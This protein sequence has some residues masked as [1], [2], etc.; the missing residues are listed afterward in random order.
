MKQA[1]APRGRPDELWQWME[2][3]VSPDVMVLTEAKVPDGGPPA[4]WQAVWEPDGIGPKRRWG[5]V[6]AG[7]GVELV[8]VTEMTVGRFRRRTVPLTP[9]IPAAAVVSDVVVEGERWATV[10]GLYGL[11]TDLDG[12][13]VGHGAFTLQALLSDLLPLLSSNRN[14]RLILAGDFNLCPDD[15]RQTIEL[16]DLRNLTDFTRSSRAPLQGCTRCDAP[17]PKECGHFWTHRNG[18]SPN[19][20]VQNIDYIFASPDL[21][22]ELIGMSGGVGDY[23]DAWDVSDHAPVVADFRR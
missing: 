4:G 19:A 23:P 7:R 11:T 1:V 6:V 3:N 10:V 20:A 13:K 14:K 15:L 16:P 18:N 8:P 12:N 9:R 22:R 2:D 21:A 5:T 17:T